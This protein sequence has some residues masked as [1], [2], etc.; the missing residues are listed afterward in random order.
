MERGKIERGLI[1]RN[2]KANEQYTTQFLTRCKPQKS[3]NLLLF[4]PKFLWGL[5]VQFFIIVSLYGEEGRGFFSVRDNV[6]GHMQQGGS[7]S[8]FDRN[9]GTKMAAK[10]FGWILETAEAGLVDGKVVTSSKESAVLLGLRTRVYQFQ[11]LSPRPLASQSYFKMN[12]NFQPVE[13]LKNETDFT[14]RRF[15]KQWWLQVLTTFTPFKG[16]HEQE[17]FF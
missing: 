6:L 16:K 17:L 2:E 4:D 15:K 13:E 5:T 11:V 1:L 10:A 14:Y 9:L 8:P 12:W 3:T 7:P